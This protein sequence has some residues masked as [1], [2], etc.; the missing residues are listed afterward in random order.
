MVELP[1]L[2]L[3]TPFLMKKMFNQPT[4]EKNNVNQNLKTDATNQP[5]KMLNQPTKGN[6]DNAKN[7]PPTNK[8][9]TEAKK[10]KKTDTKHKLKKPKPTI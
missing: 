7:I 1:T 4:E 8:N 3:T 2:P 6:Q 5:T 9:Q 10:N